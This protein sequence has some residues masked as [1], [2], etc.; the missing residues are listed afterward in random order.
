MTTTSVPTAGSTGDVHRFKSTAHSQLWIGGRW[1]PAQSGRTFEVIDPATGSV[2]AICAAAPFGGVEH[3]GLGREGGAEG[4]QEYLSS[5][6]T[7]LSR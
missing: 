7:L 4:I 1:Q 6:Y 2:I 5:T 3:S